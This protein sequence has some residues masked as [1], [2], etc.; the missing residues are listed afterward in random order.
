MKNPSSSIR[1]TCH[2]CG[3]AGHLTFQCRNFQ[4]VD[5]SRD[6]VLDVSSTSSESDPEDFIS[7]LKLPG[8]KFMRGRKKKLCDHS[9]CF[10]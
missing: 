2:K 3:Y 5:P 9:F 6:V 7:P 1:S 10:S 4:K 8:T